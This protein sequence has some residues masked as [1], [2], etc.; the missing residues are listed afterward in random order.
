MN[1][2]KQWAYFATAV[3]GATG[4]IGCSALFKIQYIMG[5]KL[6]FFSAINIFGPLS[7]LGGLYGSCALLVAYSMRHIV[8]HGL[9]FTLGSLLT[10]Y[11][12]PTLLAS[13]YWAM[14]HVL[15]RMGIPLVSIVLFIVHPIGG[16]AWYYAL[17]WLIPITLHM[18]PKRAS[19]FTQALGSTFIAHGAGSVIWLYIMPTTPAFWVALLPLVAVER[20]LFASGMTLTYYVMQRGHFFIQKQLV[21]LSKSIPSV[22]IRA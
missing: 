18:L 12:I 22:G 17:Y 9:S 15:I 10:A 16:Q 11:H 19:L 2:K 20:L 21:T 14:P 3:A 6:A 8:L 5:S 7:G 13:L 1:I 4:I